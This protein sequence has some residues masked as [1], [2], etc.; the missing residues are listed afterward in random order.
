MK[1]KT[2]IWSLILIIILIPILAF[3]TDNTSTEA[4]IVYQQGIFQGEDIA[5][6]FN[7][8]GEKQSQTF[9]GNNGIQTIYCQQTAEGGWVAWSSK[10]YIYTKDNVGATEI[11][12]K[13]VIEFMSP[14]Q[15]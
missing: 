2:I 15:L 1:K 14:L 6:H 11:L 3:C 4:E 12:N 10:R 13:A 8:I 9:F 7:C 5:E